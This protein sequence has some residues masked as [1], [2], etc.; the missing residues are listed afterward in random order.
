[1]PYSFSL[2]IRHRM[3]SLIYT[4]AYICLLILIGLLD[5][6]VCVSLFKLSPSTLI[7]VHGAFLASI[8]I[9]NWI[10]LKELDEL[11]AEDKNEYQ[12]HLIKELTLLNQ[13]SQAQVIALSRKLSKYKVFKNA[14][15]SMS[16]NDMNTES[17]TI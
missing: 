9:E 12:T 16:C 3:F 17:L 8:L 14:K 7:M 15:F 5:A 2:N 10:L 4:C 6:Y 1:M 11:K 13:N